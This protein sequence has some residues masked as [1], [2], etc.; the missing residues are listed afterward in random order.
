M[1]KLIVGIAEFRISRPPDT[2]TTLGLGSCIGITLYDAATQVG[3]LVHI[4]LP[5]FNGQMD[6]TRAKFADT[7]IIDLANRMYVLGAR[8]GGLVAKIAGGAHMFAGTGASN[9]LKIGDRNTEATVMALRK[10]GIPIVAQDTGST[11][12]RTIELMLDTG[13]LH[14]KTVGHGVRVL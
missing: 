2:I 10:L 5:E 3:G 4:M 7:G 6:L 1:P 11:Y 12:G 9:V 14:V 13:Q 8:R